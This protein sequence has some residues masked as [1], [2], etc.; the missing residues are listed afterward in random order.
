MTKPC[1]AG[2]PDSH[3]FSPVHGL[4]A[5]TSGAL[6]SCLRGTSQQKLYEATIP[7]KNEVSFMIMVVF[8]YCADKKS[9]HALRITISAAY[10]SLFHTNNVAVQYSLSDRQ[11]QWQTGPAN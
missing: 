2:L 11:N 5:A 9:Q 6:K 4:R 8:I 3:D 10:S 1:V 7:Q